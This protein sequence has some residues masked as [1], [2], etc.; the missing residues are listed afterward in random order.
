M[1]LKNLQ[2]FET[3]MSGKRTNNYWYRGVS[4]EADKIE[5]NNDSLYSYNMG[6]IWLT[7]DVLFAYSFAES[8][9]NST[10]FKVKL[11]DNINLWNPFDEEDWNKFVQYVLKMRAPKQLNHDSNSLHI[12]KYNIK[13]DIDAY[14]KRAEYIKIHLDGRTKDWLYHSWKIIEEI[15]PVLKK[16]GYRGALLSEQRMLTIELFYLEDVSVV[17]K[18][19]GEK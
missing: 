14:I 10:L 16:M 19:H 8:R 11:K 15:A 3:V 6:A 13:H 12:T 18:Q 1:L 4:Q 7:Q 17:D 2:L 5:F 9:D